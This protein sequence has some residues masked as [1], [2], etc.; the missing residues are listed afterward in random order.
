MRTRLL[1]TAV[2][3]TLA[4]APLAR[5]PVQAQSACG[6]TYTVVEGDTLFSIARRCGLTVNQILAVN[7]GLSN[8]NRIL[9][10]QRLFLPPGAPIVTPLPPVGPTLYVVRLGDTLFSIARLFGTTVNAILARNPGIIDPNYIQV[11]QT[12]LIPEPGFIPPTPTP[13][14]P[15]IVP[16]V[17]LLPASGPPG[18]AVQ[19][20]GTRFPPNVPVSVA[21][22]RSAAELSVVATVASDVQG[23]ASAVIVIPAGARAPERWIVLLSTVTAPPVSAAALFTVLGPPFPPTPAPSLTPTRSATPIPVPTLTPAP[24]AIQVQV[25]AIA[26]GAGDLGCGDA[27]VA[28]PRNVLPTRAPLFAALEELLALG[29]TIRE[30]PDLY[31]ALGQSDLTVE[32]VTLIGSTAIVRLSGRLQIGGVCDAPRVRAQ[33]ERAVL[34]F[35]AVQQVEVLVNGR[36]LSEVLGGQG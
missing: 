10:G 7:P 11:G 12:I 1:V 22:G 30:R 19:V 29:P 21:L 15:T 33:L 24:G 27:L 5:A 35:T 4:L 16:A 13:F 23:L 8:P 31:N 9:V 2:L 25:Y 36:G 6:P 3:L 34:Q 18:T 32:G 14:P 20:V 26:L 17:A 28:L